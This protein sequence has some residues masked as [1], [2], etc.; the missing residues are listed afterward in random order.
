MKNDLK[1]LL[2]HSAVYGT[3]TVLGKLAGFIMLPIYTRFLTPEDYG[4]YQ[5]LVFTS[6]IISM[7]IAVGISHA[8]LRFYYQ[9]K[10]KADRNEVISTA[11]FSHITIFTFS[12]IILFQL[13]PLFSKLLFSDTQHTLFFRLI[14]LYLLISSGYE[15]PLVF[16]RA[17]QKST[18]FVTISLIRLIISLSLNILF[19]AILKKGVLGILY[20]T[21]ISSTLTCL[22][23]SFDTLKQVHF[24]FSLQKARE[25]YKFGAPLIISNLGAFILTFSDRYFL[26][27][28]GDLSDVGIYSLGYKFGM[29]MSFFIIAPFGKIWS[30]QMF[31]VADK[32][33]GN[34]TFKKVFT[35]LTLV[36]V[37]FGLFLSL[38]TKDAIRVMSHPDYWDAHKVVPVVVLAYAIYG[39][40]ILSVVGLYV[41]KRTGL[42][43]LITVVACLSNL[44]FNYLLISRFTIMGAAWA[45][46]LSFS[47][48]FLGAHFVSQRIMPITYEWFKIC[49]LFTLAILFYLFSRYIDINNLIPSVVF[50]LFLFSAFL[51]TLY[52]TDIFTNQEK[53]KLLIYIK[54]PV[55]GIKKLK[56]VRS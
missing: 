12:F 6:N 32:D 40:Y 30:A 25:M 50:N 10:S 37:T 1:K 55:S 24:H 21:I 56:S 11:M 15:V 54:N 23:L 29:L 13:S 31:E 43:A 44:L 20:S 14:F 7:V 5:L 51:A 17:Q 46:V 26:K 19:V 38:F 41:A 2:K 4:T 22:Y 35:Y 18:K 9:Y 49:K 53:K 34:E 16:I 45:T 52:K 42:V 8:V 48:R 27:F 28:Y 47:I 36:L 39:L 3:G 33:D